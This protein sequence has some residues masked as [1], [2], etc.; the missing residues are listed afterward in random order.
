[1]RDRF[2]NLDKQ[3]AKAI[4]EAEK[5]IQINQKDLIKEIKKRLDYIFSRYGKGGKLTMDEMR[6]YKRMRRLEAEI[7]KAVKDRRQESDKIIK[8]LLAESIHK[9]IE[10]CVDRNTLKPTRVK[11]IKARIDVDKIINDSGRGL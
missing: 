8:S 3:I 4:S 11:A 1:M 2:T 9:S 7:A 5:G 10:A 6:K